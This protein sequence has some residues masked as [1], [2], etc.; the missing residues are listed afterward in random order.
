[1]DSRDISLIRNIWEQQLGFGSKITGTFKVPLS[2]ERIE[3]MLA[4]KADVIRLFVWYVTGSPILDP[5][6]FEL[7]FN[8]GVDPNFEND[9][10]FR[11][12][13]I[14]ARKGEWVISLF[15]RWQFP[16]T[17]DWPILER[18]L[19][20]SFKFGLKP[21]SFSDHG[22]FLQEQKVFRLERYLIKR[23]CNFLPY[24]AGSINAL[25]LAED[26]EAIRVTWPREDL[27]NCP[28]DLFELILRSGTEAA[29]LFLRY[30][31]QLRFTALEDIDPEKIYILL[32]SGADVNMRIKDRH[33]L[34]QLFH[35]YCQSEIS[36]FRNL[37]KLL[38]VAREAGYDFQD[39]DFNSIISLACRDAYV[40]DHQRQTVSLLLDYGVPILDTSA[41]PLI[42]AFWDYDKPESMEYYDPNM[43]KK[44][45]RH[46]ASVDV[47][48][49]SGRSL[50]EIIGDRMS[51][52]VVQGGQYDEWLAYFEF[53]KLF[54]RNGEKIL[55]KDPARLVEYFVD[56]EPS[57]NIED[58]QRFEI[59]WVND[60]KIAQIL[61]AFF[62]KKEYLSEEVIS[63]LL[64]KGVPVNVRGPSGRPPLF[65]ALVM[66]NSWGIESMGDGSALFRFLV[67]HGATLDMTDGEGR[68]AIMYALAH[69]AW[70][71]LQWML[72]SEF[73]FEIDH[74]DNDGNTVIMHCLAAKAHL[75]EKFVACLSPLIE[76][77]PDLRLR[78]L[79][80]L[81]AFDIAK[82][83]EFDLEACL[84]DLESTET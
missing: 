29:E 78:N 2:V 43:A 20:V 60:S 26:I 58:L 65:H 56:E 53:A 6:A 70:D 17:M 42:E 40:S 63:F 72:D 79:A 39:A 50:M 38:K 9:N 30:I 35:E 19:D 32:K 14:G 48:D 28:A 55:V 81:N 1:M 62:D 74:Q 84:R 4:A 45:I 11:N 83:I 71:A 61:P 80:G 49:E 76:R 66:A 75:S 36:E 10:P 77:K 25:I 67:S 15:G 69:G 44:L 47:K 8:S 59:D 7:F 64:K 73:R 57:E 5:A 27:K 12:T 54:A 33:W 68:N 21:E 24:D 52:M 18:I 34:I 46:G 51:Q 16:R 82:T 22:W 37:N 3:L 13:A 23:G 41:S 31:T